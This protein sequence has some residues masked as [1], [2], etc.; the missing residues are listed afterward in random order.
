M[1]DLKCFHCGFGEVLSLGRQ[2]HIDISRNGFYIF[3]VKHSV[4]LSSGMY[5]ISLKA[6]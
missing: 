4:F 2:G 3:K 5:Y 6:D 1:Q